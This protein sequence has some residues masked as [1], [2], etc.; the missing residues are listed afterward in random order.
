MLVGLIL[1]LFGACA[2]FFGYQMYRFTVFFQGFLAGAV[3]GGMVGRGILLSVVL[4][5]IFGIA[6][7]IM[8]VALLRLGVFLQ[9]SVSAFGILFIPRMIRK[10][11]GLLNWQTLLLLARDYYLTGEIGIDFREELI[12]STIVGVI[13][14][15]IGLV[16]TRIMITLLSA[17]AGGVIAGVGIITALKGIMP[18]MAVILGI[19][20]AI[21]GIL[22][23]YFDWK[24]KKE[25]NNVQ[26]TAQITP[27]AISTGQTVS[28]IPVQTTHV[29]P[30]K[31]AVHYCGY[32][33]TQI[34]DAA[35]FCPK[36]GKQQ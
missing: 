3:I 30:E 28:A 1:I 5:L 15:L 14:G 21:G 13:V 29:E 27:Q 10:I 17:L 25:D 7:G 36:C 16:F 6:I 24:K 34:S 22:Y 20:L 23:Q 2:A 32:C 19:A 26:A 8:A 35:K 11:M 9:C 4:G 31:D 18:Q 12:V 33:G